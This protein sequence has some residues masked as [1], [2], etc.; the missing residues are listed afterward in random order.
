MKSSTKAV[1]ATLVMCGVFSSQA[2]AYYYPTRVKST[3]SDGHDVMMNFDVYGQPSTAA[4]IDETL[5]T[6]WD[7]AAKRIT[8]KQLCNGT[9]GTHY[10]AFARDREKALKDLKLVDEGHAGTF[11]TTS[12]PIFDLNLCLKKLSQ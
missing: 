12:T 6:L 2:Q 11:H 4:N 8:L 1:A 5:Q 3:T 9:T 10:A 7:R